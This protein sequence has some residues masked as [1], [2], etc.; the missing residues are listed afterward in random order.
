[1]AKG[2]Y[3]GGIRPPVWQKVN[4]E[5][6]ALTMLQLPRHLHADV[7][8]IAFM[9]DKGEITIEQIQ[10]L[11]SANKQNKNQ[12]VDTPR[13]KETGILGSAI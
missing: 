3:R 5:K 11:A 7:K 13:S 6:P 1:M 8:T 4:G 10:E 12:Q 2:G 9:L